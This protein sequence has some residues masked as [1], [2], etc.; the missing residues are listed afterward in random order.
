MFAPQANAISPAF[1]GVTSI[2]GSFP[3]NARLIP[4]DGKTTSVPHVLSV[5]RVK[6]SRAGVPAC[7]VTFAG[8]KPCSVTAMFAD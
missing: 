6:T 1:S 7:S 8:S 5:V 2:A 3:G 4:S